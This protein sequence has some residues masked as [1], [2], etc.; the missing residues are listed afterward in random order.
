MYDNSTVQEDKKPLVM[1]SK[2]YTHSNNLTQV[3][4]YNQTLQ[5]HVKC[6]YNNHFN[7]NGPFKCYFKG[8]N[9][10]D[11]TNFFIYRSIGLPPKLTLTIHLGISNIG[12]K[13]GIKPSFQPYLPVFC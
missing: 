8:Q 10:F 4:S 1:D 6:T 13:G 12:K 11:K 9:T 5:I 2:I 3:K 7:Y